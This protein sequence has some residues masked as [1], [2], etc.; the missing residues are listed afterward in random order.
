MCD[1]RL[2]EDYRNQLAITAAP[3]CHPKIMPSILRK[4]VQ[5]L[6]DAQIIAYTRVLERGELL[7]LHLDR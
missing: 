2:P 6:S 7:P 3:Y 4:R 5:D 1:P